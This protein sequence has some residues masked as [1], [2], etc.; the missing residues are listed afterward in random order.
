[1]QRTCELILKVNGTN[2]KQGNE[3]TGFEERECNWQCYFTGITIFCIIYFET[4]GKFELRAPSEQFQ[5]GLKL[6][7]E[8]ISGWS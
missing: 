4:S 5:A 8:T 3:R 2:S 6:R 1:M 7:S